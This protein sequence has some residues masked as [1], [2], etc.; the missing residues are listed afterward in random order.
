MVVRRILAQE[1][2]R[3]RGPE[4]DSYWRDC[5]RD[6]D[7]YFAADQEAVGTTVV[8]AGRNA[9][10]GNSVVVLGRVGLGRILAPDLEAGQQALVSRAFG[11]VSLSRS[12]HQKGREDAHLEDLR[13]D[14]V[15][16]QHGL[17]QC[18]SQLRLL[19]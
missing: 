9:E 17:E 7:H 5:E 19:G 1:Q 16:K 15:H 4:V 11:W 13:V 6:E 10:E 2:G 8:G 14:N 18:I 3:G 12:E